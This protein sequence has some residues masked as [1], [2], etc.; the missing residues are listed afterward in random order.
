MTESTVLTW[1]FWLRRIWSCCPDTCTIKNRVF[2]QITDQCRHISIGMWVWSLDLSTYLAYWCP[3]LSAHPWTS[4]PALSASK[5]NPMKTF[6]RICCPLGPVV[7]TTF[8]L[9][10]SLYFYL[11]FYTYLINEGC[12]SAFAEINNICF[13]V[14][15]NSSCP[16]FPTE[17]DGGLH[18]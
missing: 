15:Y 13:T 18:W 4:L 17:D 10:Y 6:S 5:G 11:F 12:K 16:P 9:Y 1:L 7:I 2:M 8:Y 3:S 14:S